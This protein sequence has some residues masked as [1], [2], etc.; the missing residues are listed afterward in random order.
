[1]RKLGL[2]MLLA[3][4][5]AGFGLVGGLTFGKPVQA[6]ESSHGGGE[7]GAAGAAQEGPFFV[8]IGPLMLP[9]LGDNKV[10]QLLTLVVALEVD[11]E[12]TATAIKA[13][14]PKLTDAYLQVLYGAIGRGK[15][16]KNN[17]IDVAQV[18]SRLNGASIKVLGP[19]V[20]RS[21]L[22]QAVA[23]RQL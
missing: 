11:D 3:V 8:N 16:M 17:V 22:V 7:G 6:A 9:V 15:V 13:K 14:T 12:Q 18:K 23:Q 4:A 21:V 10:Q 2:L 20:V 19:G 1:M 5:L